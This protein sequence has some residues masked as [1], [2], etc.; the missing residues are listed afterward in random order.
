MPQLHFLFSF[1]AH[2]AE[3]KHRCAHCSGFD[4]RPNTS[5]D[6]QTQIPDLHSRAGVSLWK[7]VRVSLLNEKGLPG[8]VALAVWLEISVEFYWKLW[9]FS[10]QGTWSK[11]LNWEWRLTAWAERRYW[12]K[13]VKSWMYCNLIS[14][15]D[16]FV[17]GYGLG[18][19]GKASKKQQLK[20]A[21]RSVC[22]AI[23]KWP[24]RLNIDAGPVYSHGSY[25]H[26]SN[27]GLER[28]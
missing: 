12:P 17:V 3:N 24:G 25:S 18:V 14:G 19:D 2:N 7:W 1:H 6:G 10:H 28:I 4:G 16:R 15:R 9:V 13:F 22:I 26:G 23:L 21:V 27:E 20:M 11:C 5:S 8:W